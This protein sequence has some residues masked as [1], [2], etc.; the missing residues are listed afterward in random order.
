[1]WNILFFANVFQWPNNGDC[2]VSPHWTT[3]P[4]CACGNVASSHRL[5]CE[6]DYV[7]DSRSAW[8]M[9]VLCIGELTPPSCS[10]EMSKCQASSLWWPEHCKDESK[11]NLHWQQADVYHL[12]KGPFVFI[13]VQP[14][15]I[16]FFFPSATSRDHG[17]V[18]FL[19]AS[20]RPE[21]FHQ[22]QCW[23]WPSMIPGWRY[24]ERG[25]KLCH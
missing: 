1:M 19:Q 5:R 4:H 13:H 21:S 18:E 3:V 2:A 10:K 11:M 20:I 8:I 16:F 22:E 23:V 15:V 17:C 25:L 24:Q 14:D 9:L 12:L 7:D 6:S